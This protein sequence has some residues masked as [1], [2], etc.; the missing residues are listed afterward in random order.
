MGSYRVAMRK[1]DDEYVI[2]ITKDQTRRYTDDTLPDR[3]KS[4]L[5][6][7][8]A[9]PQRLREPWEIGSSDLF[10]NSQ[11]MELNEVGWQVTKNLYI[12]VLDQDYLFKLWGEK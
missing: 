12:V 4:A 3:I 7:I 9:F 11:T 1:E 8:H 5:S 10:I 2:H 6:M